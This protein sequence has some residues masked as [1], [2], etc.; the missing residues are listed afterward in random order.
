MARKS[1]T[2]AP[3]LPRY[4]R[5]KDSGV[6]WLGEMPEHW[7]VEKGKW[8]FEKMDRPIR[9]E[10][11]VVTAFRDGQVTLRTNRRTEGFTN[12]IKEHGY[13]GIR[14]GDLVIHAMDAFAGAIGVSES[15]GKSTP[16]YSACVPRGDGTVNPFFYAYLLRHMAHGGYITTLAKGIRER[17]TDFRYNDFGGLELP[18]PP[19]PEQDR[20]VAFL[21]EKTTQIDTLIAKKRRQIELLDEHK[22]ILINRMVTKGLNP[23]AELK[24][25]GIEWI[26]R[27]P[28]HWDVKSAKHVC[29]R[30]IDCKNRTPEVIPDG[31]Y[32]VLRTSNV[33]KGRLVDD[34]ITRTD[35]KHFEIWTERGAPQK[36]DVLFT[37]EAPA[38]EACIFDGSIPA[39][40]GQRMM[41]FRTDP[42]QLLPQFL[43]HTIYQGPSATYIVLKTNGSTVG[44][45]RLPQVY[46]LP[47]L[48][49]PVEEQAAILAMI[50]ATEETERRLIQTV[51]TQIQ[52]LN[53]LRSTLIAH[54]VTGR[55]K[56]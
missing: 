37:R 25:S 52:S 18:F 39:C 10:D 29:D 2:P 51:E 50:A 27:I 35:L 55:I 34:E 38:G 36:N 26:G 42:T 17:S 48:L 56:I 40:L 21:D 5:Y 11:D 16:V 28:K 1:Q 31:G 54:V 43:V 30:I 6:E 3:V 41:Y 9:P 13:Q 44:H 12:A 53:S 24:D 22:A 45:L 4:P 46:A 32:Y 15:D 19:L 7:E 33:K 8:L 23:N 47:I 20:I 14:K 49:P